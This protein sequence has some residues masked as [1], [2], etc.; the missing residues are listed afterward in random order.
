[1]QKKISDIKIIGYGLFVLYLTSLFIYWHSYPLS[2]FHEQALILL[3]LFTVLLIGSVGVI[4]MR[5]W[6]RK[7]LLIGNIAA[8][9]YL[10]SLYIRFSDFIPMSYVFLSIVITLFFSQQRIQSRFTSKTRKDWQIILLIDDEEALIKTVRPI[11]IS[12]GYAVLSAHTGEEGLW[13]AK[14]Q[15]PDLILLDVILPGIKGRDV[16][17]HLKSDE[18]TKNIPVV[19]LTAKESRDDISAEVEAGGQAHL[20]KPV[21]AQILIS[22]IQKILSS[23]GR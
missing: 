21:N 15:K 18:E 10:L 8:A 4:F 14:N 17:K 5:E 7:I 9:V 13:I 3:S 16:C 2:Q 22:T 11:L 1:M 19:F 23:K 20:T 6:G 12:H